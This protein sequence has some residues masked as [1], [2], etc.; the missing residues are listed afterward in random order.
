[1]SAADVHIVP[2]AQGWEVRREGGRDAA[3]KHRTR[4]S[5]V[6]A[7]SVLASESHSAVIVHEFDGTVVTPAVAW[8]K[9]SPG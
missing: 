6:K 8:A 2:S 9:S 7:G 5:A 1:M 4:L 3:S